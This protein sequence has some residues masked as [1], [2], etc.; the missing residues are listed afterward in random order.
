MN[1]SIF[2]KEVIIGICAILAVIVLVFG[3]DFLKGINLFHPANYYYV[4]YTDVN[5]LSVSAPVTVNGFKVGQVRSIEYEYDNPG[6]VLVELSLDK[7]LKIPRGTKAIITSD[8][9]GTATVKL[10]MHDTTEMHG[11]GD[12]ITGETDKGML[13]GI[14]DSLM[15]T[16]TNILP[17]IDSLLTSLDR[18]V[19]DPALTASVRR[20]DAITAHI[21][22]TMRSLNTTVG[23]LPA[24]MNGV[25][26]TVENLDKLSGN[27]AMLSEELKDLP[28]QPVMANVNATTANLKQ[29]TD[30]LNNPNSTLGLM[31]HDRNL[32][33]NLN[34]AVANLD[35]LF[36]DIKR[37]PK[38]YI[39][40][41]L[42]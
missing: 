1:K 14:G 42:L 12:K 32:Y 34:S 31:L 27:L 18:I 19:S 9:L 6:H 15:P 33:D 13:G 36:V 35:S 30:D 11:I 21:E 39:N 38:R 40:I 24:T 23:Q 26:T 5:G 4:S 28:I 29:L 41:K 25:N 20:L 16:V 37:S 17:K 7:Q 10:E 22:G 2:R 3:I 8:L